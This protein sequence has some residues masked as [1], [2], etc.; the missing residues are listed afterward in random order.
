VS[1]GG[2]QRAGSASEVR[3]TFIAL[4][5]AV[6]VAGA[7]SVPAIDIVR[8]LESMGLRSVKT[9]LQSGNAVF[10]ANATEAAALP[11]NI[12]ASLERSHGF[13]PEV[14]LLRWDELD[15]A[16]NAN[17]Y[18]QADSNPKALHLTFL[19]CAPRNPD[20]TALEKIRKESEQ[21]S[22][23]GRVFYFWAPEGVGRSKLFSRIE[24]S[25]GVAG[26]ARNWRTV[27]KLQEMARQAA[28]I[29]DV[30]VKQKKSRMAENGG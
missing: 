17:P 4:L 12:T 5:R 13:A 22:L 15:R 23:K 20:L 10:Q 11:K 14:I 25:L 16:I 27:C 24:K 9:Y 3:T 1:S 21:F 2:Q 28:P 8:I 7:N 26:T 18:P 30:K 6:N 19:A 29:V